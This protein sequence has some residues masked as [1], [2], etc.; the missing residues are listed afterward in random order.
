MALGF[1]VRP[2]HKVPHLG[3]CHTSPSLATCRRYPALALLPPCSELS[4]S[5]A[6]FLCVPSICSNSTNSEQELAKM[7]AVWRE[8]MS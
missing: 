6:L 8:F 5:L 4:L 7:S 2:R 1:L 3:K